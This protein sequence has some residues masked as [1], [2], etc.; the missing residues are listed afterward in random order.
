MGIEIELTP[1]GEFAPT[2]VCDGCGVAIRNVRMALYWYELDVG[3]YERNASSFD[4]RSALFFTHK[5]CNQIFEA[6]HKAM[7][8]GTTE[9]SDFIGY[10][11]T[12][13]GLPMQRARLPDGGERLTITINRH[14]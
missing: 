1:D 4:I 13:L 9:L 10:L 7:R 5:E 2:V 11:A 3:E 8:W 6:N 14:P 12:N